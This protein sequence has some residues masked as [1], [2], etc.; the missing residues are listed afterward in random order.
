LTAGV[1]PSSANRQHTAE[2]RQTQ[3]SAMQTPMVKKR[4]ELL[5]SLSND[6]PEL[7]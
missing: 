1:Q 6:Q 5:S 4:T 7:D 3:K 2:T